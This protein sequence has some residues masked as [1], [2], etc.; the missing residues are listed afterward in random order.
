MLADAL[1]LQWG[2]GFLAVEI[3]TVASGLTF[4]RVASMGPRLFSRGNRDHR[5]RCSPIDFSSIFERYQL[6]STLY[7]RS[8]YNYYSCF[9]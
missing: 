5:S 4:R 3:R 1:R 8:R 9:G 7:N 6:R 2:H